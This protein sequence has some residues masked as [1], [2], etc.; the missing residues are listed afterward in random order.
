MTA[1]AEAGLNWLVVKRDTFIR[2]EADRSFHSIPGNYAI[3][4]G[5]DETVL[6]I[7]GSHY[8]PLQ[9][10]DAFHFFDRF[11]AERGG[12]Y[13]RAGCL[14]RGGRVWLM[15]RL[16]RNIQLPNG[17]NIEEHAILVNS[18]D[19]DSRVAYGFVGV[20]ELNGTVLQLAES[21]YEAF[22]G[23]RHRRNVARNVM[24]TSELGEQA[25]SAFGRALDSFSKMTADR[26]GP[27]VA[28]AYFRKVY[29]RPAGTKW[30]AEDKVMAG[31][32]V[33]PEKTLWAAYG[34]VIAQEDFKPYYAEDS[35]SRRLAHVWWGIGAKVKYR[36][37]VCA[38]QL[39]R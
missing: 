21:D 20:R 15:A 17:E 36:A 32:E 10:V 27:D 23:I 29:R 24:A 1:M 8:T 16:P 34:V 19:G 3:V 39:V 33:S 6:G 31:F 12:K 13:E 25:Q 22:G 11:L 26:M 30:R 4:R 2:S 37:L 5:D 7:V 14:Y 38:E 9:N 18:H 35:V 28:R